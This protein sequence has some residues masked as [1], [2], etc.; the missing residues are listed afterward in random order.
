MV[1]D[2]TK[3]DDSPVS[4]QHFAES[5]VR[6]Y[7]VAMTPPGGPVVIVADSELQERPVPEGVTLRVPHLTLAAPPQ[8]DAGAVAELARMLV[9]ASNPVLIADRLART[10][11]GLT[12]RR[13]P[14]AG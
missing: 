9:G 8:A 2:Y 3:W 7:K 14:R 4:L 5:A 6:A 10:P 11:A 12:R 13:L 1:R